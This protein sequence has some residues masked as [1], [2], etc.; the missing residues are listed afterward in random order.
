LD[1]RKLDRKLP[2][3][4]IDR[5][6]LN[7]SANDPGE[8]GLVEPRHSRTMGFAVAG[9]ND[10]VAQVSPRRLA[11]GPAKR[12]SRESIPGDNDALGVDRDYGIEGKAHDSVDGQRADA[13]PIG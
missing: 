4:A 10:K 2:G 3:V 9:R 13:F 8:A 1:D 6:N 11:V 5:R 12:R 7:P